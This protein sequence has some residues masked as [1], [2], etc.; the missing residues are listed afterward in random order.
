MVAENTGNL[1]ILLNNS[2]GRR[3]L[4][5]PKCS[6]LTPLCFLRLVSCSCPK[7]LGS[8]ACVLIATAL[9]VPGR[10]TKHSG[11]GLGAFFRS[12]RSI[13]VGIGSVGGGKAVGAP[14]ISEST[15][16][17]EGSTVPAFHC[18]VSQR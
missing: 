9:G 17:N 12:V 18:M 7:F 15:S 11:F 5:Q 3:R 8:S 2:S 10:P 1:P 13:K 4:R 6:L 16:A 14:F